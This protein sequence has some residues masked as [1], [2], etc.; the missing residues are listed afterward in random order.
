MEVGCVLYADCVWKAESHESS[1]SPAA[2][3]FFGNVIAPRKPVERLPTLSFGAVLTE[4]AP[5]P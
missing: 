2:T 4:N 1:A 3:I 5:L